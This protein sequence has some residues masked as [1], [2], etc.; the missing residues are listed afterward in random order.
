MRDDKLVGKA[1]AARGGAAGRPQSRVHFGLLVIAAVAMF[2]AV[3][4]A[5]GFAIWLVLGK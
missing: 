1:A 4:G 5:I 2:V 3:A